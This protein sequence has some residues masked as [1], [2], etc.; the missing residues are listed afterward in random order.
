MHSP[1]H[2]QYTPQPTLPYPVSATARTICPV[3]IV[4]DLDPCRALR[5][6]HVLALAANPSLRLQSAFSLRLVAPPHRPKS[7]LPP[8]PPL[9]ASPPPLNPAL[10]VAGL[11]APF[12]L[13]AGLST[14]PVLYA[15]EEFPELKELIQRKFGGE[16]DVASACGMVMRSQGLQRTKDLAAFHAQAAVDA[17]CSM[18]ACEERDGLVNLCHVVLSRSS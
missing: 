3:P 11:T 5:E 12:P 4:P 8:T 10:P 17:C 14:A 7:S 16:G 2:P 18:P 15:A 9:Q 6:T 13:R 1:A